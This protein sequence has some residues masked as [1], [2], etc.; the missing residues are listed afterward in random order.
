MESQR[1]AASWAQRAHSEEVCCSGLDTNVVKVPGQ[2][3]H[4]G[5]QQ[6]RLC[7]LQRHIKCIRTQPAKYLLF[8]I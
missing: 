7:R 3:E 4:K 5:Q 1:H 6:A 2:A 8:N